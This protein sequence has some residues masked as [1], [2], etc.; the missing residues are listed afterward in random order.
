MMHLDCMNRLAEFAAT[1]IRA[2]REYEGLRDETDLLLR[3]YYEDLQAF[4]ERWE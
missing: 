1:A 2:A 3:Q 4:P